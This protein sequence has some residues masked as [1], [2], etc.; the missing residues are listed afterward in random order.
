M[1]FKNISMEPRQAEL[2]TTAGLSCN[3]VANEVSTN[4]QGLWNWGGFSVLS[5]N[6]AGHHQV[7]INQFL[8][9]DYREGW[10][11]TLVKKNPQGRIHLSVTRASS[12]WRRNVSCTSTE[13]CIV[14]FSLTAFPEVPGLL[15]A[16]LRQGLSRLPE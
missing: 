8:Y 2:E 13:L 3:I 12:V 7:S 14:Y 1:Q 16:S 11:V 15:D 6:V 5:Q 10:K 4:L 9:R